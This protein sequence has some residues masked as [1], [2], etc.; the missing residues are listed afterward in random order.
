MTTADL[1]L[2]PTLNVLLEEGSV[3]RA[4]QRL[5]LSTSAMSRALARLRETTGDPLLV[6]AG[7]SLVLTPRAEQLRARVGQVVRE[8]EAVLRPSRPVNLSQLTRTFFLRTSEGFVENFGAALLSRMEREAPRARVCFM[9]K[10]DK[11]SRPLREGTVDLE[12]G[13]VD[14]ALGPEVRAKALFQDRFVGVVRKGHP[15]SKVKITRSLYTGGRHVSV[16]RKGFEKGLVEAAMDPL[17]LQR[18]VA[19][20][21]GGFATALSL[22]RASDLI[23]TVPAL[24]TGVLRTDM[25]SFKLPF[26]APPFVVSL[27]WHPRLDADPAHSWLRNCVREVCARELAH[28]SRFSGA[29]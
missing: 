13:V 5:R 21:V 6:R 19:V 25:H 24:H 18:Q 11:D 28:S 23:A 2:L 1:N 10:A 15:L 22:A 12:T 27:L 26:P 9:S 16:S 4:A 17:G 29:A 20:V 7:R 14:E 3:A 8:A